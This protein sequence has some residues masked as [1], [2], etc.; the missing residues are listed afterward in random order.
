[1]SEPEQVKLPPGVTRMP[2]GRYRVR[3]YRDKKWHSCGIFSDLEEATKAH[4]VINDQ[5][6]PKTVR[7][8]KPRDD[9]QTQL[10]AMPLG[11]SMRNITY[12]LNGGYRVLMARKFTAIYCGNFPLLE[13]AV[14]CR[15]EAEAKYKTQNQKLIDKGI[16]AMTR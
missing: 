3:A 9:H 15:D 7:K 2:N 12:T 13:D 5:L 14:K 10:L 6:G 16:K 4:R 1:M 11:V 8:P